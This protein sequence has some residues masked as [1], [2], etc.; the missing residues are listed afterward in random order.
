MAH[1][2]RTLDVGAAQAR[3]DIKFQRFLGGVLAVGPTSSAGRA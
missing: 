2:Q 1:L 3:R